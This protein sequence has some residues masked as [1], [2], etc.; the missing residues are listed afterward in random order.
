MIM[1]G[2]VSA[3]VEPECSQGMGSNSW[4]ATSKGGAVGKLVAPSSAK[5]SSLKAADLLTA[6]AQLCFLFVPLAYAK[7]KSSLIVQEAEG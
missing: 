2:G 1:E 4:W 5:A 6:C 7:S 3:L